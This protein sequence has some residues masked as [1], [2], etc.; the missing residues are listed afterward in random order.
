[1][2]KVWP[3]IREHWKWLV[4]P[5]WAASLVLVWIFRGGEVQLVPHG[6]SDAD[7]DK[8]MEAKDKAVADFRARL[9]EL[10]KKAEERLKSASEE[11]LKEYEGLKDKPLKE[12]AGWID[13]LS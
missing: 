7:V 9:D 6:A 2:K 1:M 8:A 5:F 12:I 11:Q 10:A 3:W 4:F 13:N